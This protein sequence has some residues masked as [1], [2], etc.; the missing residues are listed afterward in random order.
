MSEAGRGCA[1]LALCVLVLP[2]GKGEEERKTSQ[3][4]GSRASRRDISATGTSTLTLPLGPTFLST[5][6]G[7]ALVS[8]SLALLAL[9]F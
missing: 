2:A 1:R 8:D 5:S 4:I 6:F 3:P 9:A 7:R